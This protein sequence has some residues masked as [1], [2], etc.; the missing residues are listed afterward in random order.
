MSYTARHYLIQSF[1]EEKYF[2]SY[3]QC[4]QVQTLEKIKWILEESQEEKTRSTVFV[5]R[6]VALQTAACLKAHKGT[7]TLKSH[8]KYGTRATS[9]P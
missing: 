8:Q 1:T 5:R 7:K 2:D 4:S 6:D 9:K 3:P